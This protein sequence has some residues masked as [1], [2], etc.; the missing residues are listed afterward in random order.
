MAVGTTSAVDSSMGL[1]K[2]STSARSMLGLRIP[3][4]VNRSFTVGSVLSASSHGPQL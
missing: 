4:D 2:R 1:P 3:D